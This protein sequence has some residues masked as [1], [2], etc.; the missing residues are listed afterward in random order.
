LY[1]SSKRRIMRK[2]KR[3][4][5]ISIPTIRYKSMNN[6]WQFSK[7]SVLSYIETI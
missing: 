2:K 7:A 1:F 6:I 3:D 5:Y 4:V